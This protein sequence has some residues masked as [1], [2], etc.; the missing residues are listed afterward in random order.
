M[1]SA[2]IVSAKGPMV[3]A[4]RVLARSLPVKWMRTAMAVNV[5]SRLSSVTHMCPRHRLN[6][7]GIAGFAADMLQHSRRGSAFI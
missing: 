3:G 6:G 1:D 7:A 4:T 5:P 2:H